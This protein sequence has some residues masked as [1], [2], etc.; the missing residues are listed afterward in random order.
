MN[1]AMQSP[2]VVGRQLTKRYGELTAVDRVDFEIARGECV[3][4]LGPNG[5]GKTTLMRMV[6]SA[7]VKSAGELT[8]FGMT[9]ILERKR[10]NAR[11]GVVFQDN[12]LDEELD[13]LDNLR[14][15]AKYCGLDERTARR[16]AVELLA[17]MSLSD[18]S[19]SK[20]R[21]LSGGMMRRLMI[22]RALLG[23]P[24]LLILDEPSTGLD[25]QVRHAIWAVLRRLKREGLTIALTTHYM[26]EAQALA[27]R[28]IIMD[29]GR[30]ILGGPPTQLVEEQMERF[31]LQAAE[32]D[33]LPD[34]SDGV[35][36]E[37]VGDADYFYSDREEPLRAL[38]GE[39]PPRGVVL[40]HSNLEDV[41]FKTT[42]RGLTE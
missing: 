12:N 15:Y 25:P 38:A 19:R 41:F 21:E 18:K 5:A 26:E 6:F 11:V 30:I 37:Q 39:L 3:A 1:H 40:R 42:G 33:H 36:H 29:R 31:V 23:G 13:V 2:V 10:I 9:P 20:V 24:Q 8:V 14:I 7:V 27:D 28:A 35:R 32:L 4:F 17:L 34:L 16:H 22:A